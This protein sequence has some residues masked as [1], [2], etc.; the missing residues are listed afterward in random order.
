MRSFDP[1]R[2]YY[3][4]LGVERKANA[5]QIR[6]AYHARARVSHPDLGGS[7]S[8]MREINEAYEVLGNEALRRTYDG[9]RGLTQERLPVWHKHETPNRTESSGIRRPDRDL[10]W[11][12][13]RAIICALF[14][15]F[16]LL[17]AEEGGAQRVKSAV[18]P[19]LLRG[20][21]FVVLGVGILFGYSAHRLAQQK[22][23]R[24]EF[25]RPEK[26]LTM[27]RTIFRL[28]IVGFFCLLILGV[29]VEAMRD[30]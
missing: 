4:V 3:E 26:H 6:R 9:E 20:L 2:D 17:L 19:W 16:C 21:S 22:I 28:V 12:T 23:S 24:K 1:T 25:A 8:T 14:A 29:L 18:F 10:L 11:L 30:S 15:M 7:S 13:T 5:R 27:C